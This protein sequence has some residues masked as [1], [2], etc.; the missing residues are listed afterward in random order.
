MLRC[1]LSKDINTEIG[2][3]NLIVIG[4]LIL[5]S[6]CLSLSSQLV[7]SMLQLILLSLESLLDN[8]STCKKSFFEV[9]KSFIFNHNSGFFIKRSN[10]LQCKLLKNRQQVV[11]LLFFFFFISLL[12]LSHLH[13]I[14]CFLINCFLKNFR[15]DLLLDLGRVLLSELLNT[16]F[17]VSS[18][19]SFCFRF[20]LVRFC[21]R[22]AFLFHILNRFVEL[23]YFILLIILLS[24]LVVL[25]TTLSRAYKIKVTNFIRCS[26]D[27]TFFIMVINKDN[28][29]AII[30][31]IVVFAL[32]NLFFW[33]HAL[34]K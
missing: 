2:F 3:V 29:F 4:L 20:V 26:E 7:E 22:I 24:F 17:K 6:Q 34:F 25:I 31:C 14:S 32:S 21:D 8:F 11:L 23:L 13:L 15:E 19:T 28:S 5:C 30:S 33:R 10:I 27:L 9:L 12:S 16:L 1:S 18:L